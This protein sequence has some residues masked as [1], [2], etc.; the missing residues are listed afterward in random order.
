[1]H[2]PRCSL[3]VPWPVLHLRIGDVASAVTQSIRTHQLLFE[4][5]FLLYICTLFF[6]NSFLLTF[7]NENAYVAPVRHG[8]CSQEPYNLVTNI[9]VAHST[10]VVEADCVALNAGG[11]L[12]VLPT[13]EQSS[14]AQLVPLK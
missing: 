3:L 6:F 1:M 10:W 9:G 4:T 2:V 12:L 14:M 7:F 11:H 5:V 13:L 8:P